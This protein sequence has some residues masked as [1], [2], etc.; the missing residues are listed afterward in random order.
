MK[1][2]KELA[3]VLG[4]LWADGWIYKSK[5][6]NEIYSVSTECVYDDL[7]LLEPIF[8]SI[9]DIK[10]SSHCRS[11][12]N[13][14]KQMTISTCN[15]EFAKFLIDNDYSSKS[16]FS[17]TKILKLIPKKLKIYFFRGLIDGDGCFYISPNKK[18]L[19]FNIGST[20]EQDW[21]SVESFFNENDIRYTIVK[22]I[23]KKGHKDSCIRITS[24]YDIFKLGDILYKN[25]D[26]IYLPR[27]F[28][29]YKEMIEASLQIKNPYG[30]KKIRAKS[31][32]KEYV[33]K[34][35]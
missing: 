30:P 23:S 35:E 8:L 2:T 9:K 27:K 26:K 17:P 32:N 14:R 25:D 6:R 12:A 20:F 10:W 24:K 31:S 18:C 1:I 28:E 21:N 29:K 33:S 15:K 34:L 3:Y 11:R 7:I 4:F 19:Q 22:R 16:N 5:S 13:R